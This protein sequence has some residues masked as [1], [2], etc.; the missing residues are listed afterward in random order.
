[1]VASRILTQQWF[2]DYKQVLRS[3]NLEIPLLKVYVDD[4]RQVMTL[5]KKGMRYC[6]TKKEFAWSRSAEEDE[7][8]AEQGED[9]NTFMARLC[10]PAMI[11]INPDLT[12]IAEVE[13]D[14]PNKQLPTLDMK[15]WMKENYMISNAY[16][17]KDVKSQ[18]LLDKD[19]AMSIQQKHSILANEV[20]R[21]LYNLDSR[22]D[23]LDHEVSA[24]L[25]DFTQQ[26][27]MGDGR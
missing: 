13:E 16:Y 1:M 9:K 26:C 25:E 11:N 12:F 23:D 5:L 17:K 2:E 18:V 4:G 8:K 3:A 20:T 22:M 6:Q 14:F 19:S 7:E 21:R 15:M 27:K 24:V 10:L